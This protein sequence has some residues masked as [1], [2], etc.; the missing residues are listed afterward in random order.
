ME[1]KRVDIGRNVYGYERMSG[2]HLPSLRGTINIRNWYGVSVGQ[3]VRYAS[4]SDPLMWCTKQ[5]E[6]S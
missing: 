3:Q 6:H 1:F 4:G 2:G 5:T